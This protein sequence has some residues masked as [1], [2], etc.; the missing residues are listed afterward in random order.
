M[1][2]LR[3]L[4]VSQTKGKSFMQNLVVEKMKEDILNVQPEHDDDAMLMLKI[5]EGSEHALRMI[6]ERWKNPLAN[7]FYRSISD[8]HTA[9]D[10]AQQ[11]FINLYRAKESYT[12]SAKFSTYLFHIARNVLINEYRKRQRRPFDP[13][14]PVEITSSVEGRT[15]L[16]T[17]E[18]EEVFYYTLEKLPEN[19]RT[20]ILL[21]KQQ[22]M[23]Y[24]EIAEAMNATIPAVKT[25]IFR[26]RSVLKDA[27][28]DTKHI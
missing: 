6:I 9:E 26:A 3:F 23:S 20:A 15:E 14:D 12:P 8:I 24:E 25:W 11:T 13:V 19:Q 18:L 2:L 17:N 27:L 21:F 22:D 4:V 16:T 10:L 28:K 1:K 7:Y 5:A